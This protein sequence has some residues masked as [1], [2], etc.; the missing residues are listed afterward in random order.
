MNISVHCRFDAGVSQQLLQDFRRNAALNGAC[1]VGVPQ[2]VHTEMLDADLIAQFVQMC[3]VGT[4]FD[5]LPCAKVDK[6]QL[7]HKEAG[8]SAGTAVCIL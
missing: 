7:S 3:V 2:C 4:V 8:A 1:C 5:R 6:D